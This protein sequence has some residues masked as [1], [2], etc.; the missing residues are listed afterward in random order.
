M[1]TVMNI[2]TNIDAQVSSNHKDLIDYGNR[3][4]AVS[5]KLLSSLVTPTDTQDTRHI[6]LSSM[7]IKPAHTFTHSGL[8]SPCLNPFT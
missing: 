7:G 3:V 5:E 1:S 8:R 2:T 4:L 6:S